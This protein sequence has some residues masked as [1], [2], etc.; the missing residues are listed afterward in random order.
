MTSFHRLV[1]RTFKQFRSNAVV[2]IG[3]LLER[4]DKTKYVVVNHDAKFY[5]VSHTL[6]AMEVSFCK[7]PYVTIRITR[8]QMKVIKCD[9]EG[10]VKLNYSKPLCDYANK[11]FKQS[12]YDPE[13][14]Y[15]M[16]YTN[17]D[18]I[19]VEIKTIWWRNDGVLVTY[20]VL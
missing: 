14:P 13:L 18:H 20:R 16:F 6:E 2:P 5:Y 12:D 3:P 17:E 15:V 10:K 7:I 1:R 11:L 9:R 4:I 19:F 8:A